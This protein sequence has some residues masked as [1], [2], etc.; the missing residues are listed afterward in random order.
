M[1]VCVCIVCMY[2]LMYVLYL[3]M[4]VCMYLV[5]RKRFVIP[6][7]RFGRGLHIY[8]DSNLYIYIYVQRIRLGPFG[9]QLSLYMDGC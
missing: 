1:Y 4:Y 7:S 9:K 5:I 8:L 2:V 3:S 6:A